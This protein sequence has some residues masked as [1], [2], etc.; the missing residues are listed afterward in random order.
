MADD[1]TQQQQTKQPTVDEDVSAHTVSDKKVL[2]SLLANEPTKL[3]PE[4]DRSDPI[5]GEHEA[6]PGEMLPHDELNAR[7]DEQRYAAQKDEPLEYPGDSGLQAKAR[8]SAR[9][10]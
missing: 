7:A 10:K 6:Q 2:K 9:N 4:A 5:H 1:K 3:P 8:R